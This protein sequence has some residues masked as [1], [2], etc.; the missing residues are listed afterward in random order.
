MQQ[1]PATI[2]AAYGVLLFAILAEVIGTSALHASQQFTRLIPSLVV[3]V[4]YGCAIAGLSLTFRL[5]P[6]GIAYAIWSGLGIVLISSVGWIVFG[7]KLDFWAILGL[8]M[9]VAG[10]VIVNAFSK[11]FTH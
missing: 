8:G 9:I 1:F 10:I 6:M 7:H 5:I 2:S 4:F 3:I 11:S